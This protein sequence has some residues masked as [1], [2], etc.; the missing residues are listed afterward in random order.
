MSSIRTQ[1]GSLCYANPR[2][3]NAHPSRGVTAPRLKTAVSAA[4]VPI[5][6]P[7]TSATIAASTG[8]LPPLSPPLT[9]E[10]T[11]HRHLDTDVRLD[12][13]EGEGPPRAASSQVFPARPEPRPPCRAAPPTAHPSPH[14]K[15][16]SAPAS[17]AGRRAMTPRDDGGR[18]AASRSA[19]TGMTA[20]P[21]ARSNHRRRHRRWRDRCA[22]ERAATRPANP[23]ARLRG[24]PS[25]G[26]G[27][28]APAS[29][30][31]LRFPP[32]LKACTDAADGRS[33]RQVAVTHLTRPGNPDLH[34]ASWRV[35]FY[36][37]AAALVASGWCR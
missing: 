2:K 26:A 13:T 10:R 5:A 15:S 23:S 9:P 36:E 17:A 34:D 18:G 27:A 1:A 25:G 7:R 19:A 22:A 20:A 14:T 12:A 28:A 11:S 3:L 37:D 21:H 8:P 6:V 31:R 30:I 29:A 32:H 4:L 33:Q 24:T 16:P 35:E